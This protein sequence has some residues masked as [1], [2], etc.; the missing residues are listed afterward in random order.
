MRASHYAQ[1]LAE[2]IREHPTTN[3]GGLLKKFVETV[4][5]NGHANLFPR[6]VKSFAQIEKKQQALH[7]IEVISATPLSAHEIDHALKGG[8]IEKAE[9]QVVTA[10]VDDT[11]IGGTIVRTH[12]TRIDSSWKRELLALYTRMSA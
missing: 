7:T 5:K 1:A 11:L 9:H 12:A 10:R 2:L 3:H 8:G 6:I 4:L